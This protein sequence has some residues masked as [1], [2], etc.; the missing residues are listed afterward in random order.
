MQ[1]DLIPFIK[2]VKAKG[3]AVKLDTNGYRPDVLKEAIK[4]VDY[5][6]MDIKAPL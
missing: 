2:E 4:Y 6:A 1:P 5:V 3:F